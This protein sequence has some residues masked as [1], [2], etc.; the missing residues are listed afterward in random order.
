ML[1]E[2]AVALASPPG[3][4]QAIQAGSGAVSIANA[5]LTVNMASWKASV[6]EN[7]EAPMTNDE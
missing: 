3:E 7:D 1:S 2:K 4:A 6:H 5:F